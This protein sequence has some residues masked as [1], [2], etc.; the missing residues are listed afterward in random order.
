LRD[1]KAWR[2]GMLNGAVTGRRN[3]RHIASYL[4]FYRG[5]AVIG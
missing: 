3:A 4:L 2:S 1:V 5:I